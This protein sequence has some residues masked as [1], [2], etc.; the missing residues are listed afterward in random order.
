MEVKLCKCVCDLIVR[1]CCRGEETTQSEAGP[2]HNNPLTLALLVN[3]TQ[4]YCHHWLMK[5]TISST[6]FI[7]EY[8]LLKKKIKDLEATR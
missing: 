7:Y 1:T 6:S 4:H 5:S 8:E 2:G 3:N